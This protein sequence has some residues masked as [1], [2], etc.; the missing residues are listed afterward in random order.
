MTDINTYSKTSGPLLKIIYDFEANAEG[1]L[2]PA[3]CKMLATIP[4]FQ[5]FCL[6]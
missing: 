4:Q 3:G 2:T 5:T 1:M 6:Q